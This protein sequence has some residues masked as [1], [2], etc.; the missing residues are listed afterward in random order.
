MSSAGVLRL[1]QTVGGVDSSKL[2]AARPKASQW[3]RENDFSIICRHGSDCIADRIAGGLCSG[4]QTRRQL[5]KYPYALVC[6]G[7]SRQLLF[8]IVLH[9]C[10]WAR[11]RFLLLPLRL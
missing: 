8:S 2:S 6:H 5:C 7:Y 3:P 10:N 11:R 9:A 4:Q 1:E